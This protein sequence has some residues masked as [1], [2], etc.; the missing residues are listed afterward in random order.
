MAE[1]GRDSPKGEKSKHPNETDDGLSSVIDIHGGL[2][3]GES[4]NERPSATRILDTLRKALGSPEFKSTTAGRAA[5]FEVYE[6]PDGKDSRPTKDVAERVYELMIKSP[7]FRKD[8]RMLD[9]GLQKEND[10]DLY[11]AQAQGL[12]QAR[13]S[14]S[15]PPTKSFLSADTR[16]YRPFM[17]IQFGR[18]FATVDGKLVASIKPGNRAGS[19]V[20]VWEPFAN[21]VPTKKIHTIHMTLLDIAI[22]MRSLPRVV[23]NRALKELEQLEFAEENDDVGPVVGGYEAMRKA[24][25]HLDFTEEGSFGGVIQQLSGETRFDMNG[26]PSVSGNLGGRKARIDF[27]GT[28]LGRAAAAGPGGILSSGRHVG[29]ASDSSPSPDRQGFSIGALARSKAQ[30]DETDSSSEDEFNL[31]SWEEDVPAPVLGR[32]N[33]PTNAQIKEYKSNL[34]QVYHD[35]DGGDASDIL[36][37]VKITSEAITANKLSEQ[38]AYALLRHAFRSKARDFLDFERKNQTPFINFFRGLTLRGTEEVDSASATQK[39]SDLLAKTPKKGESGDHLAKISHLARVA[40]RNRAPELAQHHV[41]ATVVSAFRT[42]FTKHYP[43]LAQAALTELKQEKEREKRKLRALAASGTKVSVKADMTQ[44]CQKVLSRMTRNISPRRSSSRPA[45]KEKYPE[46][47]GVERYDDV[48]EEAELGKLESFRQAEPE[49]TY[50][51]S[52]GRAVSKGDVFMV[53]NLGPQQGGRGNGFQGRGGGHQGTGRGRYNGNQAGGKNYGNPGKNIFQNEENGGLDTDVEVCKKCLRLHKKPVVFF[54]DQGKTDSSGNPVQGGSYKVLPSWYN[55]L[56]YGQTKLIL[57]N[58]APFN[59]RYPVNAA[60]FPP[61]KDP[62]G[63]CGGFHLLDEKFTGCLNSV[64]LR[65]IALWPRAPPLPENEVAQVAVE[66]GGKFRGYQ[67]THE[68]ADQL[69]NDDNQY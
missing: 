48:D 22:G 33:I 19:S 25:R 47:F 57:R 2:N 13:R 43:L 37:L 15:M 62:C 14:T 12:E 60:G 18:N 65:D 55:C 24:K 61:S 58:R 45:R 20:I 30:L 32:V 28:S 56:R 9:E 51:A 36:N 66:G 29:R 26:R 11:A 5:P 69:A 10:W 46:V 59:P 63:T 16:G 42:I 54:P 4:E 52:S 41:N 64:S 38:G 31:S 49:E 8:V 68:E 40:N 7:Q 67:L 44:L 53:N 23:R 3:E 17:D 50:F 39:I 6:D 27:S 34:G 35:I 21:Q 1:G